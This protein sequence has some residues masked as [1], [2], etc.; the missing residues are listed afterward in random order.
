MHISN[1]KKDYGKSIKILKYN[2][3]VDISPPRCKEHL[4]IGCQICWKRSINPIPSPSSLMRSKT[5]I[6]DY[7]LSNNFDM[8]ATFTFD[9]KKVDSFNFELAKS[10]ISK[11]LNNSRRNSPDLMY[12]WVAELHKSGRIHFHMLM[13]NYL[14]SLQPTNKKIKGRKV[15]NLSKWPYGFSTVVEI[16]DIGKVSSY[17]QKYITKDMLKIGNKKRFATSRNLTRPIVD[18]N[19]NMIEEVYSR[20][21]FVTDEVQFEHYKIYKILK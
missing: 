11:W 4:I 10:K 15:Y 8:F 5:A 7:T 3:S 16:D 1:I 13:K 9:P 17:I 18:Y 2:R 12:L 20:P 6:T 14:D 19:V 21:L